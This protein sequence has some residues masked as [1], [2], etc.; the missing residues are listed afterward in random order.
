MIEYEI[1]IP[2]LGRWNC[3]HTLEC[4]SPTLLANTYL[5]VQRKE[6][7]KYCEYNLEANVISCPVKGIHKV[8]Q[9]IMERSKS[10]YIIFMSDDLK[11]YHRGELSENGTYYHLV[12]NS[13]KQNMRMVDL[14]VKWMNEGYVHVGI[15]PRQFNRMHP[16]KAKEIDRMHDCYGYEREVF[17]GLGIRFDR[18]RVMEDMDVTLQFLTRGIVN[19]VSYYYAWNQSGSNKSGGCST[20]RTYEVQAAAAEEMARLWPDFVK[21]VEKKVK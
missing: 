9:W 10:K 5:V 3:V 15:S 7:I 14:M 20:Y 4:L 8:R 19:R 17:N 21:V 18:V 16:T 2:S 11:F 12:D 13:L 6:H 1:Y